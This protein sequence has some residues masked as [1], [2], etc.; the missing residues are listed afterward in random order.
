[1]S[2]ATTRKVGR[3]PDPNLAARRKSEILDAAT[4]TFAEH[5]YRNTDVQVIADALHLGKGTIYRYFP[6]KRDLFLAAVDRGMRRLTERLM[7]GADATGEGSLQRLEAVVTTYL[8]HFEENPD[9]AELI[10]QERAEFRDREKPTYFVHSDQRRG[11]WHEALDR[12]IKD[13]ITRAGLSVEA[14]FDAMSSM[15]YGA[16]FTNFFNGRLKSVEQ[17]ARDLLDIY[18][19]GVLRERIS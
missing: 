9:L 8:L 2:T 4:K 12:L 11:R 16:M 14:M 13:E 17:Q 7:A 19:N 3:P 18:L 5:G 1:M 10:I 6:S 15:L